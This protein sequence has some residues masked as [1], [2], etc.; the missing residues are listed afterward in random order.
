MATNRHVPIWHGSKTDEMTIFWLFEQHLGTIKRDINKWSSWDLTLMHVQ[1]FS[2]RFEK[3]VYTLHATYTKTAL[4][5]TYMYRISKLYMC[6]HRLLL[7]DNTKTPKPFW[8]LTIHLW[9]FSWPRTPL[10]AQKKHCKS[11]EP[12]SWQNWFLLLSLDRIGHCNSCRRSS[13]WNVLCCWIYML[14]CL[15]LN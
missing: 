4:W 9:M 5:H 12:E 3:G 6:R 8:Q 13:G 7:Y 10:V 15:V 11:T 2:S 1:F 14:C